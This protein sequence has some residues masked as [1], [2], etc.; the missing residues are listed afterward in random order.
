MLL[1]TRRAKSNASAF[2]GG[3]ILGLAVVGAIVLIV[4]GAQNIDPGFGDSTAP[5]AI[6]LSLGILFL[7]LA[8]KRWRS[9]PGAGE[10]A[11]TPKWMTA[12]DSFTRAK[13]VGLGA[14]L[15]GISPKNLALAIAAAVTIAQTELTVTESIITLVIFIVIASV[16]IA[17]PVV[18]YLTMGEKAV[19][20]MN[21]WKAWLIANNATVMFVLFIV[22]GVVLL[23]KGIGGLSQ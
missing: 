21:S 8:V 3:W 22:F 6:R 20:T 9:R 10:E 14:L 18:L 13:S 19:K 12:I 5:A 4:S 2:L 23:G 16:S 7:I 11:R 1:F 15:S 17:I